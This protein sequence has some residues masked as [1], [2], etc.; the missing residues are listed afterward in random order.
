MAGTRGRFS[1]I[2]VHILLRILFETPF[3]RGG[4]RFHN[5][6]LCECDWREW[7][8]L[9]GRNKGWEW[10]GR[11]RTSRRFLTGKFYSSLLVLKMTDVFQ[12]AAQLK[13][14]P[15]LRK[16]RA[17]VGRRFRPGRTSLSWR[18]DS[19]TKAPCVGI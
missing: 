16:I 4:W 9:S 10:M 5:V 12:I 11:G 3:Y 1:T 17:Q 19:I 18:N 2:Y 14:S 8:A 6:N 13:P 15:P 7:T